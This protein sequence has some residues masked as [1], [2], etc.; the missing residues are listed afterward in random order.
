V[1]DDG[2]RWDER[3]ASTTD[4]APRRPEVIERWPD[5]ASVLPDS[6]R[7]LDVASGPG[8]VTLWFAT[9]GFEVTALDASRVAIDLLTD[10]AVVCGVAGR[11]D[12]RVVD[13]DDGLPDDLG[14]FDVVVCQRFRDP[15]LY[16]ALIE[17]L[18]PGGVAIVTVL[19]SVGNSDPGPFHAPPGEL[20][21]AF[22]GDERNEL[23]HAHEGDGVAH[24]MVRRR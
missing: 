20:S 11:V 5:L 4:V 8:T 14:E 6:G 13:L 16:G 24:A 3:Y 22:G 23:L 1:H 15:Q 19:S 21:D 10:A 18:R 17:R 7:C 9:H 2:P 12:A